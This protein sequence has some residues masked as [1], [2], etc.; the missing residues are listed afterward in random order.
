[1]PGV[2][3]IA[4]IQGQIPGMSGIAHLIGQLPKLPRNLEPYRKNPPRD[5][6]DDPASDTAGS[7]FGDPI[8]ARSWPKGTTG[9]GGV[10]EPVPAPEP[11]IPEIPIVP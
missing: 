2:G 9:P 4:Q 6:N 1:M 10:P 3:P 8:D 5:Y 11:I 7:E